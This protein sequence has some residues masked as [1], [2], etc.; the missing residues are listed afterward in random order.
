MA[1]VEGRVNQERLASVVIL[2]HNGLPIIERIRTSV[3]AILAQDYPRIELIL[4]DDNSTDGSDAALQAL[5]AEYGAAFGSTREGRHGICA[6]RNVGLGLAHGD[7][8]AFLDNDAIPQPGWLAA[9]VRA[10]EADPRIGA[11]ASRVMFA[12]KPDIVNSLGSIFNELFHG[13]GVCIHELWEFASP[14]DEIMYPTGNGMMLRRAAVEQVGPFDEGLL[15]FT[16]DDADYGMRLWRRGWR[17][18]PAPEALVLHL[19][20]FSKRETGMPF[21]DSRNRV[22]M[23]LKHLAWHELPR[24]VVRDAPYYLRPS[25]F[26]DYV[27][28]WWSTLTDGYGVRELLRY[29]W[30]HRGAPSYWRFFA[31]FFEPG[32]RLMVVPDNRAYGMTMTPL[33]E[34]A[35]GQG[36]EAHL[37]HGWYWAERW[38]QTPM[39]WAMRVASLVGSLPQGATALRW[40]FISRQE[41]ERTTI[42]LHIRRQ[43]DEGYEELARAS[44]ELPGPPGLEPVEVVTPCA[45]P[46]GD[47][48]LILVADSAR[49]ERG[50]F[51]RQ[52]GF[53][54]VG[55]QVEQE[56]SV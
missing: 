35:M 12:D 4:V 53:G 34:L 13:N 18:V 25:Y 56:G 8:I 27:R 31:R 33:T 15:F 10:M 32:R 22:R 40:R 11:C 30:Q 45:L 55:L 9:L 19:H 42:T 41:A 50:V 14:P 49:I 39:R 2:N 47:Y 26:K 43:T 51:P 44:I 28:Y 21:W 1:A 20:S 7:Y 36:D 17:V 52:I 6:G 54:L 23:A 5:A 3:E 48:R 29:R 37:Y 46:P 38:A 16:P 24:F